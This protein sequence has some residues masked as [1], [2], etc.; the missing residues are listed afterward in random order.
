M[1]EQERIKRMEKE[2]KEKEE[3]E[4]ETFNAHMKRMEK[5]ADTEAK[6]RDRYCKLEERK[7]TQARTQAEL[8]N[9]YM[10]DPIELDALG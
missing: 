3:R 9:R 7:L 5:I 2:E 8:R 4:R 1:S 6:I 10:R